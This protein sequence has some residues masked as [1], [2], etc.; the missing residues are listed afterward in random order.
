MTIPELYKIFQKHNRVCI[1]TRKIEPDCIFFALKGENFNGNEFAPK[2]IEMGAAYAVIDDARM[3][4]G[5]KFILVDDVLTTLQ[6]LAQHHR[7]QFQFPIIAITGS[8]GKTTTKELCAA[9]MNEQY[10]TL[11]TQGNLNNHIG[12][13]LTLLQLTDKH[14]AAIIEM[15]ANHQGEIDFLCSIAE[16]THG[17]ITN[18][19][20]AHLEGF[21]GIN[22]VK[23]GKSEMYRWLTAHK[24]TIFVNENEKY[25][26]NLVPPDARKIVYNKSQRLP[27]TGNHYQAGLEKTSPFLSVRFRDDRNNIRHIETQLV[28]EYNFNNILT[29]ITIGKYFK[30]PSEKIE[31]ALSSYIPA[32]NRSQILTRFDGATII[33]DAYNANPSSMQSALM[34]LNRMPQ[35]NK[36]AIIGDMFELGEESATEHQNILHFAQK[37]GLQKLVTVGYNFALAIGNTFFFDTTEQAQTWFSNQTFDADTCILIKGSRGMRMETLL[38]TASA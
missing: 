17:L 27:A 5:D 13:P 37:L 18:I 16:P 22:G 7:R 19:G 38:K 14:Q 36:I 11:Y 15:G 23:K 33:L 24:G 10:F 29:A 1:D 4:L 35:K 21:G 28:G 20:K 34:N 6:Q 9:V 32:M 26:K 2:A 8:N 30:V 12:V 3:K 31:R 25:L